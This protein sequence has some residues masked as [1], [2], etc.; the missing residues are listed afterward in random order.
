MKNF[1]QRQEQFNHE[2][3][4]FMVRQEQFNQEV[5]EFMVRQEQFN[6]HLVKRLDNIVRLNNLKE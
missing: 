3:R 4:N 5:R 6:H 1:M 2:I